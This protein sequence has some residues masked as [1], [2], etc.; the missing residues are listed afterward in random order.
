MKSSTQKHPGKCT[1]NVHH[2]YSHSFARISDMGVN[3]DIFYHF[4]L[5]SLCAYARPNITGLSIPI[6]E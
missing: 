6:V 5:V 4:A 1:V 3:P 2:C